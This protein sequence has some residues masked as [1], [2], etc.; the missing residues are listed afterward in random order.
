MSRTQRLL[1]TKLLS[2]QYGLAK[3]LF[4][5]KYQDTHSCP[6]CSAAFEDWDYLYTCH[7][8][9]ANKVFKKGI[10]ELEKITEEKE[11]APNIQ[12]PS[13]A[14][15]TAYKY[16]IFPTNTISAELTLNVD[17]LLQA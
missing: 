12:I 9:G 16:V 3:T 15:W 8:E 13:L 14:A 4:Q 11:T 17:F 7:D 5:H 10:D 6:V 2:N 1:D